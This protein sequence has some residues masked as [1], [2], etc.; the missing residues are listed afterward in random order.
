M[1]IG[2]IILRY[3]N[4]ELC[5]EYWNHCYECIRKFYPENPIYIIDSGS[6]KSY[7]NDKHTL[8]NTTIIESEYHGKGEL[9][10]YYYYLN[11][12]FCDTCVILHDSV[13]IQKYV[14]FHVDK[15]KFIW[16]FYHD[17]DVPQ[18]EI[19]I[20]SVFEDE[21]LISFYNETHLWT[22]CFGSMSIIKH[23]YLTFVHE[24]Y[25]FHKLLD[26][27]VNKYDRML[28]ERVIACMLQINHIENNDII[29][30]GNI[31]EYGK[32]GI[33]Y[34]E[35]LEHKDNLQLPIIKIWGSRQ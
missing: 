14:D 17:W 7:V 28:F 26:V 8:Y 25:N 20:L 27:I 10:P 23:E 11:H 15:F 2:F 24:K 34:H 3:V 5:N 19:K 31:L 18:D 13:F 30:L 29:L 9:L 21:D 6:D 16:N 33:N 22:G 12:K 32:Y 4:N 35:Y 1:E